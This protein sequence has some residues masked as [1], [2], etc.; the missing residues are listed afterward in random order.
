MGY[1]SDV[2]ITM[3]TKDYNTMLRRAKALKDTS[4]CALIDAAD[5]FK[6]DNNTVTILNWTSVKWYD[7]FDSVKWI[8]KFI[9]KIDA[10]FVYIG[11]DPDDNEE[12][13]YN[14]GYELLEYAYYTRNIEI[15]G[16]KQIKEDKNLNELLDEINRRL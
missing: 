10:T 6:A 8:Q 13:Y 15:H 11:E 1:R 9:Q 16:E 14:E 5:I 4:V 7:S 2:A 3:R 12:E